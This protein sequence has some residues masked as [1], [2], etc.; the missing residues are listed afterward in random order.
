MPLIKMQQR[1]RKIRAAKQQYAAQDERVGVQ[2][3]KLR[4]LVSRSHGR[5]LL[6]SHVSRASDRKGSAT[7]ARSRGARID[8]L[9]GRHL[10]SIGRPS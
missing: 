5:P 6:S 7:W 4:D 1:Q 9:G 10:S 3:A 8:T 2:D